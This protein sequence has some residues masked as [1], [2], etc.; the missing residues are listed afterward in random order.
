M[1]SHYEDVT[2]HRPQEAHVAF[3]FQKNSQRLHS[4]RY[5]ETPKGTM[6]PSRWF[7]ISFFMMMMLQFAGKDTH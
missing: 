2:P 6:F 5:K 1:L 4:E 7:K 3:V